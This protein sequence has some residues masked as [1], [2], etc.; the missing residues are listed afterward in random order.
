[1]ATRD[2]TEISA[3]DNLYAAMTG[4]INQAEQGERDGAPITFA[5][6]AA[7]LLLGPLFAAINAFVKVTGSAGIQI[8]MSATGPLRMEPPAWFAQYGG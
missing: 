4:L 5:T 6:W 1:M 7:I 8:I 2:E 3:D